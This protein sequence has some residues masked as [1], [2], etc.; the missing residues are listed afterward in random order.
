MD[1]IICQS[2]QS[3]RDILAQFTIKVLVSPLSYHYRV[4]N[5]LWQG[6]IRVFSQTCN[7]QSKANWI[8]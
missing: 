7:I 3:V 6:Y 5:G 4:Q 8:K 1:C 2:A